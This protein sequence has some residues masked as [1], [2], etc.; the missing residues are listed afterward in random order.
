MKTEYRYMFK[1]DEEKLRGAQWINGMGSVELEDLLGVCTCTNT[2]TVY[3][4]TRYLNQ[5]DSDVRLNTIEEFAA[6]VFILNL[7]K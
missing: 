4:V 7:E 5:I 2:H 6:Q 1:N 3:P